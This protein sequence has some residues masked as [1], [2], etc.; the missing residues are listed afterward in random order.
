MSKPK[1]YDVIATGSTEPRDIRDRFAD[2]INVKDFGAKGDGVTDDTEAIQTALN[3]AKNLRKTLF[4]PEGQYIC[5][6]TLIVSMTDDNR[7]SIISDGAT[8]K[9]VCNAAIQ[10]FFD[11]VPSTE[12]NDIL[13]EGIKID[14]NTKT[15][16]GLSISHDGENSP[17]ITLNN[18]S[19]YNI[20]KTKYEWECDGIF[21][22]GEYTNVRIISPV[23]K[24]IVMAENTG[25]EGIS[26]AF[27]ISVIRTASGLSS[28][29]TYIENPYIENIY[30]E[31]AIYLN[32]Q[33][34]IRC[35][36]LY[37][38][39]EISPNT[40]TFTVIGGVFSSIRGRAI[41]GQTHSC[42]I[43]GC[44]VIYGNDTAGFTGVVQ[45]KRSIDMQVGGGNISNITYMCDG[46][47]PAQFIEMSLKDSHTTRNNLGNISNIRV[48]ITGISSD[49]SNFGFF[50]TNGREDNPVSGNTINISN[51]V[52]DSSVPL[53][54]FARINTNLS[55]KHSYSQR[56]DV[57]I[58]NVATPV[59][60]FIEINNSAYSDVKVF[61]VKNSASSGTLAVINSPT[62]QFVSGS[63]CEGF[64]SFYGVNPCG[65]FF[66]RGSEDL[67]VDYVP[68]AN[69]ALIASVKNSTCTARIL[70]GNDRDAALYL[71]SQETPNRA[72]I[73]ASISSSRLY[74]LINDVIQTFVE[75]EAWCPYSTGS[76]KLGKPNYLWAQLYS[77]TAE[78]NTS[79]A[80]EK[81]AIVAPNEAIM[82][83]WS[84]VNFKSFQFTDAVKEKG[85]EARIHFGVI[86]QQVAEAFASEGLDASRYALFC[87]DKWDDEYEE[88]EVVDAEAVLDEQ[89]NEVTPAVTHTEKR[90]VTPAGDRYGIRYSEALALECA[91]QRWRLDKLEARLNAAD[92]MARM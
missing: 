46:I 73:Q 7:L 75:S 79:D 16:I 41:K 82:R 49:D 20:R 19:V 32:D 51:V 48:I 33:D 70:G 31:D 8:L 78:I 1:I 47:V 34:G 55:N 21:I 80:R 53:Y 44:T 85:E 92:Y 29:N 61:N 2:V 58:I 86:A 57:N 28:N 35:F 64:S 91:Y 77:A 69:D 67:S 12:D 62:K 30:C 9:L 26:G 63:N 14:G 54:Y 52:I 27:G 88:V 72:K 87:Y 65:M 71:G 60:R 45:S 18:I 39:A 6:N 43:D 3:V 25:A 81:T 84:K 59:N 74:F 13:I 56:I 5:S 23:I 68:S 66:Y 40:D 17:S 24:N 11:I 4:F 76:V 42:Y 90:L 83:A 15:N 38:S 50:T 10:K 37:D 36:S 22:S 89:G